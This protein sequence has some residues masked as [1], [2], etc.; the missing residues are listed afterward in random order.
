MVSVKPWTRVRQAT[1][2]G[3]SIRAEVTE[4]GTF[5]EVGVSHGSVF[6]AEELKALVGFLM[7]LSA[8]PKP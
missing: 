2:G 4:D 3:V 8:P 6:K 5:R 7:E 1:F